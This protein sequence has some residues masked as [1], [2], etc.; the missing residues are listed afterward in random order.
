MVDFME[1]SNDSLVQLMMSYKGQVEKLIETRIQTDFGEKSLL[2]DA[3]EYALMNG[4]KRFRPALV[5]M[6]AKAIG[7][8]FDVADAA[9]GV[10]YF[11]TASL[12]ADDLPS[13]DNDDQRRDKPSTHKVF[14]E[15]VALLASYALI[16]AGYESIAKCSRKRTLG[17]EAG[18]VCLAALENVAIN[19]GIKGTTGGQLLDLYPP[20]HS[21]ETLFEVVDKKTGTLFEISFVYGWIFGGGDLSRLNEIKEAAKHF[22]RAFQIADDICD[23]EK[24]LAVE[25]VPNVANAFGI[26]IAKDLFSAEIGKF[27]SFLDKLGLHSNDLMILSEMLKNQVSKED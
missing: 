9:L 25:G 18:A 23:R 19:T 7:K 21:L 26:R 24:D 16:S 14:G 4:G 1:C 27:E 13:M 5:F 22:G 8:G 11:H 3:C 20:D 17:G 6:I 2:R 12:I 15:S 10:E